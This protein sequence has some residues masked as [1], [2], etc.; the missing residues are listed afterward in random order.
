MRQGKIER[1]EERRRTGAHRRRRN[2][3]G[4]PADTADSGEEF[5][6]PCG[7]VRGEEERGVIGG[8]GVLKGRGLMSIT[9]EELVGAF[10]PASFRFQ[11]ERREETVEVMML[12]CGPLLSVR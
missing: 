12:T 3:P 4:I 10:T 1:I 6:Q 8:C 11:R 2:R 5:R 7:L 9:S